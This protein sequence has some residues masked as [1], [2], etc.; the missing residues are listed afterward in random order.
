MFVYAV[1]IRKLLPKQMLYTAA[2]AAGIKKL[3]VFR[4]V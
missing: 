2:V 3:P 1:K 4:G